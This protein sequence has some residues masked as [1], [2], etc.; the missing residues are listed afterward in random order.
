MSTSPWGG[1]RDWRVCL[2][3]SR[4]AESGV[5]L[6]CERLWGVRLGVRIKADGRTE[7]DADSYT[8]GHTEFGVRSR[9]ECV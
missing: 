3:R 9:R 7:S 2:E 4:I 5:D 1:T 6:G 8:A